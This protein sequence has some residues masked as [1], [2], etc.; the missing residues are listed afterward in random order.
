MRHPNPIRL[1][2]LSADRSHTGSPAATES[3]DGSNGQ[4]NHLSQDSGKVSWLVESEGQRLF[5]KTAGATQPRSQART[6]LA[7][8]TR[9]RESL[10]RRR[11][12]GELRSRDPLPLE[13]EGP[14][15]LSA[16]GTLIRGVRAS[17]EGSS[18]DL[19]RAHR[20]SFAAPAASQAPPSRRHPD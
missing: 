1:T 7:W 14:T 5:A 19:P 8:I 20:R 4:R 3:S 11:R 2:Q 16:V 15:W 17:S 13:L 9:T 10:A 12:P 18:R 6:S